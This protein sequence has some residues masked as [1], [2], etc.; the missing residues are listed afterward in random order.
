MSDKV[1]QI[2]MAR[3]NAKLFAREESSKSVL[4]KSDKGMANA[5]ARL[6][7][8]DGWGQPWSKAAACGLIVPASHCSHYKVSFSEKCHLGWY[9]SV[10]DR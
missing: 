10:I 6:Y 2:Q 1:F 7:A 8:H 5:T 3:V 4:L 9:A